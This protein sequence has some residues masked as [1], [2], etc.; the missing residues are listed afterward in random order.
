MERTSATAPSVPRPIE[1]ALQVDG[2]LE[3]G[4]QKDPRPDFF[5][6]LGSIDRPALE[7]FLA[8]M[9]SSPPIITVVGDAER[10]DF[11]ALEDLGSIEQV[12]VDDLFAY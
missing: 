3:D 2:W 8:S 9:R 12:A 10:I 5:R 4:H 7:T 6:Q 11:G 1:A